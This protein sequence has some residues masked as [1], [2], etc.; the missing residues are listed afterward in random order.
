MANPDLNAIKK[1]RDWRVGKDLSPFEL[2]LDDEYLAKHYAEDVT[3]LMNEIE[4]LRAAIGLAVIRIEEGHPGAAHMG[5]RAARGDF[6]QEIG[7]GS[8]G[9][10]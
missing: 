6:A 4:R 2:R 1:R 8:E 7:Q 5:L 10:V 3:A 9:S